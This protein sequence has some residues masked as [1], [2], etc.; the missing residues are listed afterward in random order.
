MFEIS[1]FFDIDDC[2]ENVFLVGD[3]VFEVDGNDSDSLLYSSV[4]IWGIY[5]VL[6]K[7]V[8]M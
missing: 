7:I 3:S 1:L 8:G 2:L 4:F 5:G 6:L